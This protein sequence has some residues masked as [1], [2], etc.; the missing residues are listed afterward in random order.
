MFCCQ[1]LF[2]ITARWGEILGPCFSSSTK[3]LESWSR[4]RSAGACASVGILPTKSI[5]PGEFLTVSSLATSVSRWSWSWMLIISSGISSSSEV[6]IYLLRCLALALATPWSACITHLPSALVS[7]LVWGLIQL[8]G[9]SSLDEPGVLFLC[10]NISTSVSVKPVRP[11]LNVSGILSSFSCCLFWAFS[12]CLR[13]CL[14]ESV[15]TVSS[16][17]MSY[18]VFVW[19]DKNKD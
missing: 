16:A 10:L 9:G 12:K 6:S 3:S 15:P 4:K 8:A 1:I 19:H 13:I 2:T 7:V 17:A 18:I 5:L 11:D 14:E